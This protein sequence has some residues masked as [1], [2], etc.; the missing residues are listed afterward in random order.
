MLHQDPTRLAYFVVN[1][2]AC[3][4][5]IV[6]FIVSLFTLHRWT[7]KGKHDLLVAIVLP[8][9][10]VS[11]VLATAIWNV[12][13]SQF[14]AE[15]I[16]PKAWIL[17]VFGERF[18]LLALVAELVIIPRLIEQQL[19]KLDS[20]A[21]FAILKVFAVASVIILFALNG[22]ARGMNVSLTNLRLL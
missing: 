14:L 7:Y 20:T 4:A 21:S 15:Y 8:L 22:A 13:E 17:V 9:A 1:C 2:L 18:D 10:I 6:T 5:L 3:L 12:L 19:H 16:L 11:L